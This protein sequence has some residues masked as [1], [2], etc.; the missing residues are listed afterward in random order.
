MT[1]N[2]L[3][4]FSNDSG[5]AGQISNKEISLEDLQGIQGGSA[6]EQ[7]QA[8]QKFKTKNGAYARLDISLM[9]NFITQEEHDALSLRVKY[10]P[11][12]S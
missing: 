10:G 6:S 7:M 12:W 3:D 1:S 2:K 9:N 11:Q 5:S 8:L 4:I